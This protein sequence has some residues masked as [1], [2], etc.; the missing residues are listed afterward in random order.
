M[1]AFANQRPLLLGIGNVLRSDDGLGR[2]VVEQLAR[3]GELDGEILSIHQLTPELALPMAEASLVVIIDASREGRPGEMRVRTLSSPVQPIGAAS[4]HHATPEEL[5]ALTSLAYGR[6]PPLIVIS[7]TGADFSIGE[8]LSPPVAQAL[9]LVKIF[10]RQLSIFNEREENDDAL[11]DVWRG[12]HR[13]FLD[14]THPLSQSAPGGIDSLAGVRSDYASE[15][16]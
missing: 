12:V 2:V 16:S 9:S 10:I 13:A 11:Y 7:V 8:H 4:A 6:C 14:D 5:V 1:N 15:D 3:T